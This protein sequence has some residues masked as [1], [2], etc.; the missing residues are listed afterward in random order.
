MGDGRTFVGASEATEGRKWSAFV[1]LVNRQVTAK[2]RCRIERAG[3]RRRTT[4]LAILRCLRLW[5]AQLSQ[6]VAGRVSLHAY[7]PRHDVCS[8]RKVV[9]RRDDELADRTVPQNTT[10][11]HA[12]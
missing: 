8:W 5:E 3:A 4:D 12:N 11:A 1:Q 10:K 9:E 2:R 7:I 6:R